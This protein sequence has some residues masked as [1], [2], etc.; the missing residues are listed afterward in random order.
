MVD[1]VDQ[2]HSQLEEA[3]VEYARS[4][5]EGHPQI[6]DAV[7]HGVLSEQDLKLFGY[8]ASMSMSVYHHI[9]ERDGISPFEVDPELASEGAVNTMSRL[10][11]IKRE[12]LQVELE[13]ISTVVRELAGPLVSH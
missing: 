12:E 7:Q 3:A 10:K 6:R 13:R 11:Q 8:Y 9:A 1:E 2:F 5:Q 4:I